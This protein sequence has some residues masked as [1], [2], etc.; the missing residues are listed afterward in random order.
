MYLHTHTGTC[1]HLAQLP[2][3]KVPERQK[4]TQ[5]AGTFIH[6]QNLTHCN[7]IKGQEALH[8]SE[9]QACQFEDD[10]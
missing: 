8:S 6:D 9:L 4:Q 5:Q 3:H 10:F 1:H 7:D 2:R